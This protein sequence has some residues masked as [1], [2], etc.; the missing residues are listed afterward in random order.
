MSTERPKRRRRGDTTSPSGWD[1]SDPGTT[2]WWR[3]PFTKAWWSAQW[4]GARRLLNLGDDFPS[5][6]P[7]SELSRVV[8]K[9]SR[10]EFTFTTPA[11][12]DAFPF[13]VR[14][15]CDWHTDATADRKA[16]ADRTREIEK[17]IKELSAEAQ[18]MIE[19]RVRPIGRRYPPYRAAEVEEAIGRE[20]VNC[21][22]D[23]DVKCA[24]RVWVDVCEPVRKDLQELWHERL[25]LDNY[26]D[27]R[28]VYVEQIRTLRDRWQ[29]TL[30]ESLRGVGDVETEKAT[31]IA[32]YAMA[33]AEDAEISGA[34]TLEVMLQ[35]RVTETNQL[36]KNL[37]DLVIE[38]RRLDEFDFIVQ[39]DSALHAL[40]RHLGVPVPK[41]LDVG[42]VT[43][44]DDDRPDDESDGDPTEDDYAL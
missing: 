6:P 26:G 17:S 30:L 3:K 24:I 23:G 15:R 16:M 31:W 2:S 36:F 41:P 4:E 20:L 28:E 13:T 42:T 38:R 34:A 8:V 37:S 21:M 12:G 43:E 27:I 9:K 39:S 33:L 44:S 25:L 35:E 40:L 32:P 22:N 7:R 5:M 18:D 19:R 29:E 11:M 14:V 10:Q 1:S